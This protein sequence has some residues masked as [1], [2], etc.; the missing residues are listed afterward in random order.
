MDEVLEGVLLDRETR[1]DLWRGDGI[2]PVPEEIV[3]DFLNGVTQV[4]GSEREPI[5]EETIEELKGLKNEIYFL[6]NRIDDFHF[7]RDF[8][9][10]IVDFSNEI[11]KKFEDS[12][13]CYAYHFLI[14]ST[15][16][17][18]QPFYLDFPEPYSVKSFLKKYKAGLIK[19][20]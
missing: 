2:L 10:K 3:I 1:P 16:R 13:F 12:Q 4:I 6:L 7:K 18:E 19:F 17:L 20:S 8:Q 5:F 15:L 11:N 9:N 14:G